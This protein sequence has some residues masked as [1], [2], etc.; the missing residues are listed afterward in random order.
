V[1]S[2]TTVRR[3]IGG[4]PG[5]SET[6]YQVTVRMHDGRLRKVETRTAPPVGKAVILRKGVLRPADGRP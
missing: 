1:Q 4:V 5:G 6:R 3:A 2:V